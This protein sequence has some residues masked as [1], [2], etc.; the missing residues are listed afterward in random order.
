MLAM[1][2]E[3]AQ[4]GEGEGDQLVAGGVQGLGEQGQG[5]GLAAAA[6][7]HQQGDGVPL[8]G[9][10]ELGEDLLQALVVEDGLLR[11]HPGKGLAGEAEM[12]LQRGHG[13][14]PLAL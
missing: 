14:P 5:R 9:E 10:V 1:Q 13:W 8:Q 7:G 11:G 3:R 6:L 4:G 2:A 12:L